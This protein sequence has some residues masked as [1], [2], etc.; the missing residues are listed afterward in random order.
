ME[1]GKIGR[2]RTLTLGLG[3]T[4]GLDGGLSSGLGRAH[5][6]EGGAGGVEPEDFDSR[7]LVVSALGERGEIVSREAFIL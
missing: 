5:L 6:Y 1:D 3:H 7:E 2:P 4:V